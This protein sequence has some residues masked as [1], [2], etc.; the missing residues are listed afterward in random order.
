MLYTRLRRPTLCTTAYAVMRRPVVLLPYVTWS[1]WAPMW[2]SNLLGLSKSP[3]SSLCCLQRGIR[4]WL[5]VL[6]FQS[7]NETKQHVCMFIFIWRIDTML[8]VLDFIVFIFCFLHPV[9]AM[10]FFSG[11]YGHENWTWN[12]IVPCICSRE[13]NTRKCWGQVS[14]QWIQY[15]SGFR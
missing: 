5:Y 3:S 13:N 8:V 7:T 2:I 4:C 15:F 6:R 14:R 10:V 9:M 12:H 1:F 11:N